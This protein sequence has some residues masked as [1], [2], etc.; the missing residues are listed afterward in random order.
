MTKP[1][2]WHARPAKTQISLDFCP[3]WLESS[4]FTWRKLRS[5]ATRWVH[6]EDS[7]SDWA[8]AQADLSLCWAHRSFFLILSWGCFLDFYKLCVQTA[9]GSGQTAQ[10]LRLAWAFAV[11]LSDK[12]SFCMGQHIFELQHDKTNKMMCTQQR[13]RSTQSDQSSLSAWRNIKSLATQ[14]V[15]SGDSDQTGWMCRLVSLSWAHRSLC[16]FCHAVAQIFSYCVGILLMSPWI[17]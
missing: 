17:L 3:V 16:W 12:K 7:K 11:C 4:L 8:D 5:L 10:M 9:K 15:H 6:C 14:W 1:T 2:K 13:L